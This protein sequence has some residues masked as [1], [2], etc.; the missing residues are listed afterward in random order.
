MKHN[1]ADDNSFAIRMIGYWFQRVFVAGR[2]NM[3]SVLWSKAWKE[4]GNQHFICFFKTYVEWLK[5]FDVLVVYMFGGVWL[6]LLFNGYFPKWMSR[7]FYFQVL[8]F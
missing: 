2:Q 5:P 4:D 7:S 8:R 3:Q 6:F 1:I